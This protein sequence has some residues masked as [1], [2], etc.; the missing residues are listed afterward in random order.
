MISLTPSPTQAPTESPQLTPSALASRKSS[1]IVQYMLYGINA[2]AILITALLFG[3]KYYINSQID[4][5]KAQLETYK[6]NLSTLPIAQMKEVSDRL[7]AAASLVKNYPYASGVFSLVE[8]SIENKVYL[9]DMD[10]VLSEDGS[11]YTVYLTGVADSYQGIIQQLNTLRSPKYSA[12]I[13]NPQV[14]PG[15]SLNE[16][17]GDIKFSI[18][19]TMRLGGVTKDTLILNTVGYDA[20]Q[21]AAS[22]Q[23]ASQTTGT[24]STPQN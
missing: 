19:M 23:A 16:N 15:F 2:I 11:S 22:A 18:K 20:A 1:D 5:K 10:A 7:K 9:T 14:D 3:W 24:S 13:T 6:N 17:T 8:D 21:A 12:Y 4:S